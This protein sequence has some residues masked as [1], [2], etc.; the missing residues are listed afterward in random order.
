MYCLNLPKEN[1][2]SNASFPEIT[3]IRYADAR[4]YGSE[5]D[6]QYHNDLTVH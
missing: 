1:L 3:A 2:T 4:L 6:I 5:L